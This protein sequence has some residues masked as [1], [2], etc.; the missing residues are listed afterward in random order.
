[1]PLVMRLTVVSCPAISSKTEVA[2]RSYLPIS[3]KFFVLV[4]READKTSSAGA[5]AWP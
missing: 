4:G 2:M 5:C 1:M 3:P